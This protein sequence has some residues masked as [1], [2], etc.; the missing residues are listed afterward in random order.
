MSSAFAQSDQLQILRDKKDFAIEAVRDRYIGE[1][2][3][4]HEAFIKDKNLEAAKSV[5]EEIDLYER[6]LS[7]DAAT[8]TDATTATVATKKFHAGYMIGT[9]WSYTSGGID[10]MMV[11]ERKTYKLYRIDSRG[12]KA[13]QGP[14]D[15]R[16]ESIE[17]RRI[18][19]SRGTVAMT[20]NGDLTTISMGSGSEAKLIKN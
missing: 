13:S 5:K 9:K 20:L 11:F 4:L 3:I 19:T 12:R 15:W 14:K 8:A 16:V 17:E 6:A 1:L 10:Y 18:Q 2:K 7:T